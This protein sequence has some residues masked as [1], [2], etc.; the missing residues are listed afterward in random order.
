M[1]QKALA[2]FFVL[3][4]TCAYLGCSS[5]SSHYLYATIP[6]SNQ[7]LA[8]REDPNSG[9]LTQISGS[10]YSV[11]EGSISLALHPSGNFLYAAN[12]GQGGTI[13]ND[14]SLFDIAK[15]G[16]LAEVSP[17]TALGPTASQ[18]KLLV[19]DP[20]GAFLYVMNTGSS[21][22]SVFAIDSGSGALTQVI[23]GSPFSIGATLLNMALSP[24]GNFLFVSLAGSPNGFIAT[25]S[26]NAGQ[27]SL[28][29][30]TSTSG[31]NP[32]GLAVDASGTH[33]YA[34]NN[35]ASSSSIAVFSVDSSGTLTPVQGSPISDG[36][37]NPVDM[38][39][40]P[41]GKFLYVANQG[42]NNVAVFS[43]DANGLPLALTTSTTT[44][45]F[46]TEASPSFLAADPTGKYIYVGNQGTTA[47][48]QAFSVSN[49]VLTALT[50]YNVGN[51]PNSIAV[52]GK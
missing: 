23:P 43:I 42:S 2:L 49:G 39:F 5:N 47:G 30:L 22:I 1:L 21:N 31:L 8:Y 45:A 28:V 46:G 7:I 3:A 37:S 27:L 35:N 50:T 13:E 18:P 32:Y 38:M 29:G 20:G 12:P 19:M 24:S 9:V 17:R 25:Y 44:N 14:I 36:Y 10:P 26:V 33:V 6:V 34:G 40:D 48:I 15:D 11:G 4:S 16:T 52:L 41:S 51:T